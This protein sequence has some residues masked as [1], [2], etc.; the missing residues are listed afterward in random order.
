MGQRITMNMKTSPLAYVQT[1]LQNRILPLLPTFISKMI[2]HKVYS[3][4]SMTVSNVPV[5]QYPV[6]I[7]GST[8]K[9]A[10]YFV[11]CIHPVFSLFSYNGHIQ[12]TLFID[13]SAVM[14]VHL[15]KSM[16]MK[17]LVKFGNEF[18]IDIPK[19]MMQYSCHSQ[20][21]QEPSQ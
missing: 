8:V 9:R 1:I 18:N 6:S 17:S 19:S 13:D 5:P 3:K 12:P 11:N 15:L 14:Q 7:A 4:R 10:L 21:L 16:F 2:V 20:Q